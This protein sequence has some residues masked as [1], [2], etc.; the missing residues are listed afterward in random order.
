MLT[1]QL[2][3]KQGESTWIDTN[4][5]IQEDYQ[6]IAGLE[7]DTSYEMRLVAVDGDMEEPSESQIV[8]TSDVGT[9]FLVTF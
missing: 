4:P 9:F 5:E 7:P 2:Y 6:E 8:D 1:K 3:R